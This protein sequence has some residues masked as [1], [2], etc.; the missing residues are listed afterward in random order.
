MLS[1]VDKP[2]MG[3]CRLIV[4]APL[5]TSMRVNIASTLLPGKKEMKGIKRTKKI[6]KHDNECLRKSFT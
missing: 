2:S 5:E 1:T 6:I 4:I 3:D